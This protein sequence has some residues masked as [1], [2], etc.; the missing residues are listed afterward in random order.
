MAALYKTPII[1]TFLRNILVNSQ[2]FKA[3]LDF[4][5]YPKLVESELEETFVRGSGPGGQAV[6]KT[7]N[8]V[9]LRHIP[10]NIVVKCHIHRVASRNRQ[11]A[12]KILLNK[13]DLLY[14]GENSIEMQQKAIDSRKSTEK[15]RRQKKLAEMKEKWKERENLDEK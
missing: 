4:S 7:S 12:R 14:N 9:M 1:H 15:N 10:T 6:N 13:L 5:K 8:C 3:T 11:E 2:R